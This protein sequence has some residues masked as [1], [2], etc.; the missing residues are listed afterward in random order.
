MSAPALKG[1]YACPSVPLQCL[2]NR[3]FIFRVITN[4]DVGIYVNIRTALNTALTN[5]DWED[6]SIV[7]MCV[8]F[9]NCVGALVICVFVFIVFCIVFTVFLCCFDYVYLF[10]LVLSVLVKGLMPPSE[11]SIAVNNNNNNN[12]NTSN[13]WSYWNHFQIIQKIRERHTRKPWR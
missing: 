9:D 12:N 4:Q 6:L 2:W 3:E 13:N 1:I 8:C 5:T 10:L 7:W 11:N